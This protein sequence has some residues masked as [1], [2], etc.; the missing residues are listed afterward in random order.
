MAI[1]ETHPAGDKYEEIPLISWRKLQE[2]IPLIIVI[3]G[4]DAERIKSTLEEIHLE[5]R[6]ISIGELTDVIL[7]S[8][9]KEGSR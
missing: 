5:D 1:T 2:D 7:R 9:E 8:E 6:A 4:F 3:P